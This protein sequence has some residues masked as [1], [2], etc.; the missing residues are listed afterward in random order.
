MSFAL[1]LGKPSL[2]RR[3][4]VTPPSGTGPERSML[5]AFVR[6]LLIGFCGAFVVFDWALLGGA[7]TRHLIIALQHLIGR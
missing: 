2:D 1:R 7:S 5:P 6:G 3:P 4:G